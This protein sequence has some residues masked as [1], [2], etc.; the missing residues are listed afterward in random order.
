MFRAQRWGAYRGL[1][2]A[3][4]CSCASPERDDPTAAHDA[5]RAGMQDGSLDA[6]RRGD[7]DAG[8][9][10]AQDSGLPPFELDASAIPLLPVEQDGLPVLQLWTAPEINDDAYSPAHLIADGH[11]YAAVQAKYRGKT[12][13]RFP[14]KSFTV[15][16]AK[17]DLFNDS[18]HDFLDKRRL[19]L[20]ASFDDNSHLRARLA[21][22]LWNRLQPRIQVQTYHA[23]VFL[24][25]QYQGLY[26]VCDHVD[27]ELMEAHDLW[28]GGNLYKARTHDANLRLVDRAGDPKVS[29]DLGYT[30]EEGTPAAEL[31][32]AF[33]DLAE[34]I[35][36]VATAPDA[37]LVAELDATL[38]RA[39]FESW[40]LL[41]STIDAADSAGKNGYLYHD[42]R[43]GA[44]D[45]LWHYVPWDFN[46]S[47]GQDWRTRHTASDT[48]LERYAPKNAL[49]ERFAA[50]PELAERITKRFE[51]AFEHAWALP[52]ILALVDAW[53]AEIGAAA[54]R[55]EQSWGESIR[56]YD[57]GSDKLEFTSFDQELVYLRA[58]IEARWNHA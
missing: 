56:G 46:S 43:A 29:L 26:L 41:V 48:A 37:Q 52:E 50:V 54:R 19:V 28:P 49:F 8:P 20:T 34:L 33:D 45:P 5:A 58:W 40:Y 38:D 51:A 31:P 53:G 2:L 55:D 1:L 10:V 18:A 22:E 57:W 30:K 24:N 21:F 35:T 11:Q 16:L 23:V 25:G 14:K 17:H 39:D 6:G 44:P 12:A 3:A 15:K 42:P 36:W 32:G 4:L 7:H 47:L 9:S 27:D 13:L